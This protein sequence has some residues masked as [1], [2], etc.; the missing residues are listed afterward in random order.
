MDNLSI[1]QIPEYQEPILS[2]GDQFCIILQSL[3]RSHGA[4]VAL[5]RALQC[6]GFNLVHL[7]QSTGQAAHN[8]EVP[9]T[10]SDG[11]DLAFHGDLG[12]GGAYPTDCSVIP[13]RELESAVASCHVLAARADVHAQNALLRLDVNSI[14]LRAR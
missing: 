7:N 14:W 4:C 10:Y 3:Q 1:H 11:A 5:Q 12:N 6:P 8:K 9:R 2:S 13:E